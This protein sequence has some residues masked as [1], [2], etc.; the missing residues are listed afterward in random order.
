MPAW[1]GSKR[2]PLISSVDNVDLPAGRVSLVYALAGAQG[3]F[4]V[5][6]GSDRLLP[7]LLRP[8][9]APVKAGGEQG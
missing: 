6:E 9:A 2:S 5:K 7:D 3:S 1:S 8:V 4:G